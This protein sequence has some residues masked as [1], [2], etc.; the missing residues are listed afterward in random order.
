MIFLPPS[1]YG[2]RTPRHLGTKKKQGIQM[3]HDIFQIYIEPQ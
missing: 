2:V 3:E 1:I